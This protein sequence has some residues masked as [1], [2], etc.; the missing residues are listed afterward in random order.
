MSDIQPDARFDDRPKE[1]FQI[2]YSQPHQ[3]EKTDF[4]GNETEP[5]GS[6][7]S[8]GKPAKTG[9]IF[10]M[11]EFDKKHVDDEIQKENLHFHCKISFDGVSKIWGLI[12]I[13]EYSFRLGK[14]NLVREPNLT[15]SAQIFDRDFRNIDYY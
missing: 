10:D 15:S 7:R 2:D 11:I 3:F 12:E 5:E 13:R 1:N 4:R 9:N 6:A 8:L 14:L